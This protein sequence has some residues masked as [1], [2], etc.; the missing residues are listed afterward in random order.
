M[1]LL[2]DPSAAS[3]DHPDAVRWAEQLGLAA[4]DR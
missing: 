3:E 1:G 4:G 2:A